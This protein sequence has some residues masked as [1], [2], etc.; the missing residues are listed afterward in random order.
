MSHPSHLA[1]DRYALDAAPEELARHVESCEAC[2]SHVAAA[3]VPLPRPAWLD[4]VARPPPSRW[5]LPGFA[6]AGAVAALL[7]V[8]AAPRLGGNDDVRPKGTP[9]A[10]VWIKRGD[11]VTPWQGAPLRPGDAIRLEVAPAGFPHLTVVQ[12]GAAP[13]ILYA[14]K[15]SAAG[16]A[17][18]PA[19]T[20]DAE[21]TEERLAVVLSREPLSDATVAAVAGRRDEAAFTLEYRLPK[22]RP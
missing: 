4:L 11:A 19:W 13:R 2:R 1:L 22:E 18:T 6:L 20:L 3:Q 5:R 7:A 17:L 10:T 12:L 16:T 8:F 15:P 14:A 9:A 21:G